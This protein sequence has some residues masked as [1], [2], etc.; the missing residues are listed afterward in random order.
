MSTENVNYSAKVYVV[1]TLY[2]TP[3]DYNIT[4]KCNLHFFEVGE[5]DEK[6][7]IS[8]SQYRNTETVIPRESINQNL[9]LHPDCSVR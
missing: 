1:D 7:G 8:T 5:E 9:L 3:Q 4:D 2:W 6:T